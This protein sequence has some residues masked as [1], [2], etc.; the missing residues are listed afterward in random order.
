MIAAPVLV[1]GRVV[2]ALYADQHVT[3]TEGRAARFAW[4]PALEMMARHAGRCLEGI[5]AIRAAQLLTDSPRP[6]RRARRTRRRTGVRRGFGGAPLCQAPRV[7]DQ[8]LSR[9]GC[10]GRPARARSRDAARRRNRPVP[11]ACTIN[12]C[13]RRSA[14]ASTTSVRSWFG[15]SP[16]ATRSCCETAHVVWPGAGRDAHHGISCR[17]PAA[18]RGRA[19]GIDS[20]ADEPPGAAARPVSPLA[21][22][23]EDRAGFVAARPIFLPR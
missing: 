17:A 23:S 20:R 8:A 18:G 22:A 12:A 4:R 21:R 15:R 19:G 9:G 1:G 5:T 3:G 10:A 16:R 11:H 7:G 2:A 6:S 13:P 14:P